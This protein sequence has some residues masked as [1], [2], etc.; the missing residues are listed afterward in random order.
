MF[1]ANRNFAEIQLR[2]NPLSLLFNIRLDGSDIA[3]GQ[4]A[5]IDGITV[6]R[7]PDS[8]NWSLSY[9]FRVDQ[10]GDLNA[11]EQLLRQS[12]DAVRRRA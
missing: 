11:V 9:Q 5:Q 8:F 10:S 1:R 2:R 4:S 12:Y 7:V 3:E 6:K